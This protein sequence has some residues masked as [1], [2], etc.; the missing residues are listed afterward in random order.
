MN[1][2]RRVGVPSH[3]GEARSPA[4]QNGLW[5]S[6]LEAG[7]TRGRLPKCPTKHIPP[8]NDQSPLLFDTF[9][10]DSLIAGI[11]PVGW[12]SSTTKLFVEICTPKLLERGLFFGL[13]RALARAWTERCIEAM[14]AVLPERLAEARQSGLR[15]WV[16]DFSARM[17]LPPPRTPG[18]AAKLGRDLLAM[19]TSIDR[20]I[21]HLSPLQRVI[22]Q[23]DLDHQWPNDAR[24]AEQHGVA[25]PQIAAQR[26]TA[27]SRLVGL[28]IGDEAVR[29]VLLRLRADRAV[30]GA[31][32]D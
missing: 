8:M 2:E 10:L 30:A 5:N 21:A 1:A 19:R 18:R 26:E 29:G 23:N 16:L 7:V 4:G 20:W 15:R 11:T 25:L 22:I 28:M 13:S 9:D 24:L 6:A 14:I 27:L 12:N 3:A 32:N 31:G 17:I